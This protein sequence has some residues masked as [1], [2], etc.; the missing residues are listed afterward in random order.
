MSRTGDRT[1]IETPMVEVKLDEQFPITL[2]AGDQ[3]SY[4]KMLTN[5]YNNPDQMNYEKQWKYGAMY[6]VRSFAPV[7]Y[8]GVVDATME[9]ITDFDKGG[10]SADEKNC[11]RNR[12]AK[13]MDAQESVN[14]MYKVLRASENREIIRSLLD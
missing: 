13:R 11:I 1:D 5:Q 14:T 3:P 10:Y 12:F 9:C 2:H 4:W 6:Q 8:Q 7:F